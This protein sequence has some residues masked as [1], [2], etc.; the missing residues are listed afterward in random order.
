MRQYSIMPTLAKC[1]DLRAAQP[2]GFFGWWVVAG[3]FVMASACWGLAFYGNGLYLTH[4][5]RDL[6]WSITTVSNGFTLFYWLGALLIVATGRWIDRLGPRISASVG[7][8]SMT[9]AVILI[10]HVASVEQFYLALCFLALG[11]A[12]MSGAA[13]NATVAR[14]FDRKRGL[15]LS[16]ALTGASMGGM[17]VVPLMIWTVAKIG[18]SNGLTVVAL[19]MCLLV[20]LTAAVCFVRE[21]V[22]LGQVSDEARAPHGARLPD[23]WQADA[24]AA[25]AVDPNAAGMV[26]VSAFSPVS[27]PAPL[28]DDYWP[29]HR[30][31]R[32][33]PFVTNTLAFAL[34]LL[35][36]AGLLTHQIAMIDERFSRELAAVAV[37]ITSISAVVGRLL[38]AVLVD[39]LSRRRLAALNFLIQIVGLMLYAWSESLNLMYLACVFYGLGVGNMIAFPGLLVQ[40]EFPPEQFAHVTRWVTAM[41]QATYALGPAV[42]G[43][44][45]ERTG[46]YFAVLL[47]CAAIGLISSAL[48]WYGRPKSTELN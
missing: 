7:A 19:V 47:L 32:M 25:T 9:V 21:P 34:G 17:V 26:P 45:R 13:I 43:L 23:R 38:A 30:L 28:T 31:I 11:W 40:R 16:V 4:L 2:E 1:F 15:A 20:L 48:V 37:A 42:L 46:S 10:A 3:C 33:R 18:Y 6:G 27:V 41:T 24:N 14:W 22:I 8:L 35:A 29:L 44:I 36:Q 39:R 5:T 12:W